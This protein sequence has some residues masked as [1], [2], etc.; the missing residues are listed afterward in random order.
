MSKAI[1][2]LCV[3]FA[4]MFPVVALGD[5]EVNVDGNLR[6]TSGGYLIFTDGTA[7]NSTSSMCSG[8]CTG[9]VDG[10]TKAVHGIYGGSGALTGNGFSVTHNGTGSYTIT[11]TSA[12]SEAPH[13]VV[14][15]LGHVSTSQGYVAC[16]LSS[17]PTASS[18]TVTCMQYIPISFTYPYYSESFINS[19]LSFICL[20]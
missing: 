20:K 8:G 11:F 4:L 17:V 16:E 14:T 3:C 15:S 18:F 5:S 9:S 1:V 6:L 10:I 7:A 2:V 13:C 19:A 12:F